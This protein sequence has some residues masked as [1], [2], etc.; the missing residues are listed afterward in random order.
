MC[1][2]NTYFDYKKKNNKIVIENISN[3]NELENIDD[4]SLES[5]EDINDDDDK[6]QLKLNI[7]SETIMTLQSYEKKL[8][9]LHFI[10]GKSQ[11]EIARN[12]GVSI[13]VVNWRINKIKDKIKINYEQRK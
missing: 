4:Y 6:K 10:V 13:R 7:I 8:Y 5:L 11:R 1:L 3:I 12:I 9:Y 2:R